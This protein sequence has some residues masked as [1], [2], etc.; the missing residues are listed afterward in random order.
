M[1]KM[2]KL[3]KYGFAMTCWLL[4]FFSVGVGHKAHI[5]TIE[6][7][8]VIEAFY[9]DANPMSSCKVQVTSPSDST[10]LLSSTTDEHG[11]FAFVPDCDGIWKITVSDGIGHLAKLNLKIEEGDINTNRENNETVRFSGLIV[12][13]SVIFGLFGVFVLFSKGFGYKHSGR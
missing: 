10:Y 6:G 11:R 7:G 2:V 1:D 8:I 3:A 5:R 12:G 9:D 13:I 4:L